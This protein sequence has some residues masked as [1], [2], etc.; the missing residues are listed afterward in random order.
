[1]ARTI[2]CPRGHVLKG[3]DDT[4]LLRQ[5]RAHADEHHPEMK[6]SD[7]EIRSIVIT[8]ARDEVTAS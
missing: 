6:R 8:G 4:D 2:A 1:M 7:E 5:A 3:S